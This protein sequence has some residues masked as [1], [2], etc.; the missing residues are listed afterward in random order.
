MF[1]IIFNIPF[2][3]NVNDKKIDL[4]SISKCKRHYVLKIVKFYEQLTEN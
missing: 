1:L 3:I 2:L 4:H